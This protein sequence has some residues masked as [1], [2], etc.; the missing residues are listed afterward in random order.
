V[1]DVAEGFEV[2]MHFRPAPWGS[3]Q[4]DKVTVTAPWG[5]GER[6]WF[7]YTPDELGLRDKVA[8]AISDLKQR[9][10]RQLAEQA[11]IRQRPDFVDKSYWDAAIKQWDAGP[12]TITFKVDWISQ[13]TIDL[14]LR[15]GS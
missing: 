15:G 14:F 1:K 2:D 3:R 9:R 4:L 10:K 8:V 12:R 5:D 13:T 6:L 7:W 11:Y